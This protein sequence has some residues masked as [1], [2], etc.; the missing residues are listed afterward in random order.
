[1]FRFGRMVASMLPSKE[2]STIYQSSPQLYA[3]IGFLKS[4]KITSANN[5]SVEPMIIDREWNASIH[6]LGKWQIWHRGPVPFSS[7]KTLTF[8]D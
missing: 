4:Y 2:S 1:M 3:R 8:Y 7:C 6:V 5:I